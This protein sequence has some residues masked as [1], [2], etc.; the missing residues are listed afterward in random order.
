MT[1]EVLQQALN[2]LLIGFECAVEV[3]HSTESSLRDQM[4][5][6]CKK[7]A[8]DVKQIQDAIEALRAE[9]AKPEPE[10]V[11]WQWFG[12]TL[13]TDC[14]EDRYSFMKARGKKVRELCEQAAILQTPNDSGP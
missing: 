14:N 7:L 4:P 12:D 2:A 10:V 13:W 11:A 3:Q 5:L 9:L 8:E 6:L 1:R